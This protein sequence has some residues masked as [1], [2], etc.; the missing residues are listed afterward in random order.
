LGKYSH[1]GYDASVAM[2]SEPLLR[3]SAGRRWA[4]LP[5]PDAEVV[6][7]L[8]ASEPPPLADF[9]VESLD[10]DPHAA[11]ATA[12]TGTRLHKGTRHRRY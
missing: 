2:V 4:R 7:V 5:E 6:A 12:M 8:V 11:M 3:M 9:D 10:D 1:G